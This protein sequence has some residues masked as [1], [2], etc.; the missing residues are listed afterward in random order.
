MATCGETKTCGWAAD[1]GADAST[2]IARVNTTTSTRR[3]PSIRLTSLKAAQ[4][5]RRARG[6]SRREMSPDRQADDSPRA[7]S[8]AVLAAEGARATAPL[9]ARRSRDWGAHRA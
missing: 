6:R 9:R 8:A 4:M 1:A 5:L 7:R 3:R 2:E